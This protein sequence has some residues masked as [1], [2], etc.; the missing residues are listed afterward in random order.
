MII[1]DITPKMLSKARELA[2]SIGKLKNSIRNGEGNIAGVLGELCFLEH[3]KDANQNNTYDYDI[4]LDNKKIEIK[5]KVR[6]VTPKPHYE[7][8]VAKF[9][10]KQI[11]DYYYFVSILYQNNKYITGYLLGGLPKQEYFKQA[12]ELKKGSV[13]PANNFVVKADCWNLPISN[14]RCL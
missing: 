5:T 12:K 3:Y 14:L 8:S 9:N 7:C 13:D 10:T 11:A 1:V 2:E 4:L 6:T